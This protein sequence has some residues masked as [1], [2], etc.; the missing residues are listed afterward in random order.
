MACFDNSPGRINLTEVWI[1]REEIVDFFEYDASS[2]QT[3]TSASITSPSDRQHILEAS[4]A[5]RSK[6]SFTNELRMA[7]ALL[8]IPV[9]GCTCLST[10]PSRGGQQYAQSMTGA[11]PRT[12]VDVRAVS[13]L[14]DL[15]ALLLIAFATS[16]TLLRCLLC[17]LRAL[18]SRLSGCL[19]GS[20]GRGLAGGGSGL[21]IT[22]C[23]YHIPIAYSIRVTY[24]RSH[25]S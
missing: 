13:L 2:R 12:L 5:I 17:R 22:A 11:K 10:G 6:I 3:P 15:P 9:S 24:F 19:G 20:G 8:E 14:A 7:I 23:Q 18:A 21:V 16:C 4:V 1:S 25:F